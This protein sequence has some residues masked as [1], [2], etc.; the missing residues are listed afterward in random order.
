VLRIEGLTKNFGGL[1]VTDQVTL[2]VRPGELHAIIGP[3][4][5]GKTTLINQICGA[6]RPDAGRILFCGEDVTHLPVDRRAQRGLARS[7][8]ITSI[9]PRFPVMENVALAVQARSGSSFRFFGRAA[10]E[11]TLNSQALAALVQVGLAHR[12][13][14]PAGEL[15]HG[16]KRALE[17]AIALAMEPKLLLLDEPMAGT[18]H[19]ESERLIAVLRGLKGRFPMV[20]VE[21]DMHAVFALADRIS[22]LIYGR[23]LASGAPDEVRAD[24]QVIAAYLGDEME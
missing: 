24:P 19:D 22:V 23:I 7:F 3:N 6:L 8:Q 5:A 1:R 2:D 9:L 13:S 15:S 21:H 14:V 12:A 10:G 16:E 18:G 11:E 17:L 4:G 20:L